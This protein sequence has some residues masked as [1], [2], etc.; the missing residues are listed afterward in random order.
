MHSIGRILDD[1]NYPVVPSQGYPPFNPYD[2]PAYLP[3]D[4]NPGV[5]PRGPSAVGGSP[6]GAS[7]VRSSLMKKIGGIYRSGSITNTSVPRRPIKI[8]VARVNSVK[9]VARKD[10]GVKKPQHPRVAALKG[11]KTTSAGKCGGGRG[12]RRSG[13][14]RTRRGSRSRR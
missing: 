13:A 2:P 10:S 11:N 14:R 12:T 4:I 8:P 9:T 5:V 1:V 6:R 3:R 7:A